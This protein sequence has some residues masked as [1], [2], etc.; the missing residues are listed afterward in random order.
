MGLETKS[1]TILLRSWR[2]GDRAALDELMPIVYDELRQLAMTY[3]RGERVGHTFRPTDLVSEAYLRLAGA[4]PPEWNDRVHFFAVAARNMRQI[5]VDHAR[6][7]SAGKR[8]G[9]ERPFSLEDDVVAAG[10]PD[11]LVALD[12]ALGELAQFDERKARTVELHYF[13][14]LS[15]AEVAQVL[16]VHINTVARDLRVAEAWLHRRLRD[17]G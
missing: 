1:V 6:R 12:D 16:E 8:G 17:A 4:A 9:G 7:R 2:E 3:L 13:G 10:R 11:E 5:L 14:G 15:Q